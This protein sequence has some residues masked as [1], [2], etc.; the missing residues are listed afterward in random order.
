[1]LIRRHPEHGELAYYRCYAPRPA[2]LTELVR[3]AE[4]AG[5]SRSPSK[6]PRPLT[7]LDA[8]Q[9]CRGTSWRR[10]TLI[11]ILVLRPARRGRRHDPDP[12]SNHQPGES[13]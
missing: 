9:V 6:P 4:P 1:L 3:V 11:A 8:H 7:G 5:A 2:P 13:S 10:W 12:V